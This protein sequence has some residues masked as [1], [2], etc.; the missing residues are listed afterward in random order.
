MVEEK[1]DERGIA[2]IVKGKARGMQSKTKWW[3]IQDSNL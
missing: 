2:G 3:T 1:D